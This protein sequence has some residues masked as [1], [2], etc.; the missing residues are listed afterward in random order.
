MY[1][2]EKEQNPHLTGLNLTIAQ[3][4]IVRYMQV[5]WADNLQLTEFFNNLK[6]WPLIRHCK[7]P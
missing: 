1:K 3:R 6:A 4:Y 2:V 7:N 5:F